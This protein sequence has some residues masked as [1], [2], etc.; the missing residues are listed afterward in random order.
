VWGGRFSFVTG[1]MAGN[2]VPEISF[3]LSNGFIMPV[4]Y[5]Q[6]IHSMHCEQQWK[7][8]HTH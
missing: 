6:R 4:V 5:N 7:G 3:S 8:S 1:I 2:L